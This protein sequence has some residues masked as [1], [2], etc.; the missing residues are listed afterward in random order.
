MIVKIKE[1]K[2]NKWVTLV[3]KTIKDKAG[4]KIW[5]NLKTQDYLS[6]FVLREDGKIAI[7]KQYRPSVGK[8]TWEFPAGLRD[9]KKT[10]IS[11]AKKEV[12]EET[13]HKVKNIFKLKTLFSDTGRIDN[14]V[15][16]FF[17]K[18]SKKKIFKVERGITLKFISKKNLESMVLKGNFNYNL[19]IS[20]YMYVKLR[21]LI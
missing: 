3:K 10:I 7:I 20:L 14:K 15:H 18:C 11:I 19:H 8:Y 5:Y 1:K 9:S 2:L 17:A 16:F 6:I 4:K 12:E 13:G 21:N